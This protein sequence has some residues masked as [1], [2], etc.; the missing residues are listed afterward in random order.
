MAG[1][2]PGRPGA[3]AILSAGHPGIPWTF[4][5]HFPVAI[6]GCACGFAVGIAGAGGLLLAAVNPY[7]AATVGARELPDAL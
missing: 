1:T 6:R 2:D 5:G 7:P 4:P 3:G